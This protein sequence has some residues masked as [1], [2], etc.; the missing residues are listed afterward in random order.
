MVYA[1]RAA[2]QAREDAKA[3]LIES[4][5]ENERTQCIAYNIIHAQQQNTEPQSQAARDFYEAVDE[6]RT[7]FKCD[8][9]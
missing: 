1:D 7:R 9:K 6:I 8:Q 3:A 4:L 2:D 5:R